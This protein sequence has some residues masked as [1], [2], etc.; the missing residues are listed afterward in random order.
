MINIDLSGKTAV[1]TGGGRGLGK[2]IA[3]KLAKAGADV[4]IG[5]RSEDQGNETVEEI[6]KLGVKSGFAK[7]DIAKEDMVENFFKEAVDFA[8]GKI[9]FVINNAGIIETRPLGDVPG[10][11]MT[12]L[13][14]VN[15]VGTALVMKHGL[16]QLHKQKEGRFIAVTSIA[17]ISEMGMLELYSA[18]KAAV[19]SLVKNMALSA[20]KD[21]INVNAIA[22]GIIRTSMWEEILDS[23]SDEGASDDDRNNTF[24]EAVKDLIPF[25]NA[26][27]EEDIADTALYLV[28]DLSKEVTGQ[29]IAVDGGSAI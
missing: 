27:V 10:E 16:K 9:D 17:G 6:K 11:D 14:N 25:G 2:A 7:V 1:I 13:L 8:D 4:F 24:D 12:K 5:N 19:V 21:H 15:V 20:A 3:L 26:Q 22:P 18:S 28:S 29:I 23:M